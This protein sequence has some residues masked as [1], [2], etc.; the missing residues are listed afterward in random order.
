[1]TRIQ[2]R[3]EERRWR[4]GDLLAVVA[5]VAIG[6]VLASILIAVRSLQ[7]ELRAANEARD[8][9]ATQVEQ[10]GGSPIAGPP[11]SRG[12]PGRTVEGPPGPTGPAGDPGPT[13]PAGAPGET[14]PPGT[15]GPSGPPGPP[16]PSGSPGAAGTDGVGAPGPTGPTGPPGPTGPQGEPGPT[17]PAGKDGAAGRDGAPGQTCP[18]EYALQPLAGNDDILACQRTVAPAPLKGRAR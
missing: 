1:M 9:L 8:Q 14:G 4:R 2:L 18:D 17:G 7:L 5:A 10:L 16:G 15:Q 11:G 12:Q 3:A 13:G 6:L